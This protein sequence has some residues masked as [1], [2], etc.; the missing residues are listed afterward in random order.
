MKELNIEH[1]KQ[2]ALARAVGISEQFLSD[3]LH[4]RKPCPKF[5]AIRL[6]M[7]SERILGQKVTLEDWLLMGVPEKKKKEVKEVDNA[8]GQEVHDNQG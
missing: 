3:I 4:G 7:L 8:C 1:G 5:H 2:R 6:E